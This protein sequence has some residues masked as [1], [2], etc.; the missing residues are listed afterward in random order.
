MEEQSAFI[1]HKRQ[2]MRSPRYQKE[3]DDQDY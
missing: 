2:V 3:S 1:D